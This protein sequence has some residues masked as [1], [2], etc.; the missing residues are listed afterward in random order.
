[1]TI[2]P[3]EILL[4]IFYTAS[5]LCSSFVCLDL[6]ARYG[7]RLFARTTVLVFL[8]HLMYSLALFL[9]LLEY[10]IPYNV[11]C[12]LLS[13]ANYY[14]NLSSVIIAFIISLKAYQL[15]FGYQLIIR[16]F[17]ME[18]YVIFL[19]FCFPLITFLPFVIPGQHFEPQ[20]VFSYC[21]FHKPLEAVYLFY[22]WGMFFMFASTSLLC[23]VLQQGSYG[24][25]KSI[26]RFLV[27]VYVLFVGWAFRIIGRF[28]I[29][30]NHREVY[31]LFTLCPACCGFVF[32]Y[33]YLQQKNDERKKGIEEY[34][35]DSSDVGA[36]TQRVSSLQYEYEI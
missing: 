2:L 4:I 1:M 11:A 14:C 35:L 19:I 34:I 10:C 25:L 21:G 28:A 32:L 15:I 13:A 7:L 6:Y 24:A 36:D 12:Q 9:F 26:Q 5:F 33:I 17:Q 31:I 18:Y 29:R 8:M 27:Y 22:G 30:N 16:S 20:Y 23:M 3:L